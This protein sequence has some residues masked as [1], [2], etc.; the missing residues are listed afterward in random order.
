MTPIGSIC[1]VS[2]MFGLGMVL[3]RMRLHPLLQF[4]I[5]CAIALAF[6]K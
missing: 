2:L 3:Q 1:F 5:F 6:A 4:V